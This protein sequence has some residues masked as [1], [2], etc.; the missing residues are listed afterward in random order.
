MLSTPILVKVDNDVYLVEPLIR[1]PPKDDISLYQ[2]AYTLE[3][4]PKKGFDVWSF[5]IRNRSI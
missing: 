1:V 4:I 5:D 3:F 2:Q